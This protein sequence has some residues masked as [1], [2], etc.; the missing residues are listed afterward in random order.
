M[1]TRPFRRAGPF[2]PDMTEDER[3]NSVLF[4]VFPNFVAAIAQNYSL[5][6]CSRPD[7]PG[8]VVLHWGVCALTNDPDAPETRDYVEL[9]KA[10]CAEDR[11][12]LE[13]LQKAQSTR[14]YRSGPLAPDN[15]EG[16][17]WDFLNYMASRMAAEPGTQ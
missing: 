15:F 1:W 3:R 10:F 8:R 14:Y 11:A 7:G 2:H 9:C 5:F 17:I 13:T 6:V 16:T 4:N 12:K